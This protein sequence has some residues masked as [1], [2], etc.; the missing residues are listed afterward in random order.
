MSETAEQKRKRKITIEE[1]VMYKFVYNDG[2]VLCKKYTVIK[3]DNRVGTFYRL[4]NGIYNEKDIEFFELGIGTVTSHNIDK[5]VLREGFKNEK[6]FAM[7][8]ESDS[9]EYYRER[10]RDKFIEF[11]ISDD[12]QKQPDMDFANG[13]AKKFLETEHKEYEQLRDEVLACEE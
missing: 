2:L 13:F 3:E 5:I 1:K 12:F 4:P 7:L 8:S 9:V 6:H 10:I 11:I